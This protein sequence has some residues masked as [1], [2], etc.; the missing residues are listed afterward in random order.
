MSFSLSHGKEMDVGRI[1][2]MQED[3]PAPDAGRVDLKSW[4][5]PEGAQRPLELEIGS[6]KATFLLRQ[7]GQT[8]QVNY[9]GLEWAKQFW[10]FAAD[11][12][13]RH[14]LENVRLVRAEAAA[15]VRCYVPDNSLRQ[16][17]I[18]FPDPWPKARHHKRRLIQAPFLRE[19]WR[20]LE[21]AGAVEV[22]IPAPGNFPPLDGKAAGTPLLLPGT[23]S[24]K[25]EIGA[26]EMP[27]R[28]GANR[29]SEIPPTGLIRIAT[30]HQD[31]FQWMGE[32]AAQVADLFE[33]LDFASP[34][35]AG[36]GELVGSNFERKY[37]LEGRAFQGLILRK[38]PTPLKTS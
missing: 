6:G 15:F 23:S 36:E 38:R 7:A 3:L 29:K 31:Y 27:F 26:S 30:D 19:L 9:I 20:V 17:H 37:R 35:S 4:F 13:R 14:S 2:L 10:R 8:P 21:P 22:V 25:S 24:S 33:K 16:I 5:G 1:G 34:E 12:C 32:H 18:Y 28:G 11:R